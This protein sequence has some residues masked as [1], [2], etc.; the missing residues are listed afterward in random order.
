MKKLLLSISIMFFCACAQPSSPEVTQTFEDTK[1]KLVSFGYKRMAV[2]SEA[3]IS[4]KEG[5]YTGNAGCNG[6][7]G[8][9]VLKEKSLEIK[10]GMSTLMACA[11]MRLETMFRQEMMKVTSYKLE[12]KKL[13]LM[14]DKTPILNFM[15]ISPE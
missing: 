14:H 2:P 6:M 15:E 7:G 12:N 10:A 11:D 13:V 8:K 9:Y 5:A 3:W 1:W 4:F